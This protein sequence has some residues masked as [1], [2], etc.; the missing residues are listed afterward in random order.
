M[1]YENYYWGMNVIW[2]LLWIIMLVWIF[3]IPYNIPF[4]RSKRDSSSEIL[5]KRYA[6]GEINLEEFHA[7]KKNII[8]RKSK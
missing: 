3:A 1:Y 4:Q 2:W 5:K 6:S 7:M 8:K